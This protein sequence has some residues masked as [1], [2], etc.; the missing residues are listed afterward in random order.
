MPPE[1][2]S[3]IAQAYASWSKISDEQAWGLLT[4]CFNEGAFLTPYPD[5]LRIERTDLEPLQNGSPLKI[6]HAEFGP[7]E[8]KLNLWE[9]ENLRFTFSL[10]HGDTKILYG[11]AVNNQNPKTTNIDLTLLYQNT[12]ETKTQEKTSFLTQLASLRP[13]KSQAPKT[14]DEIANGLMAHLSKKLTSYSPL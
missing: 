1:E 3:A 11:H 7:C 8:G 10:T 5:I 12:Q 2:N 4:S 13:F 9:P 6:T 14:P